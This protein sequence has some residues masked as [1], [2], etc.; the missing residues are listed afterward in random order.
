MMKCRDCKATFNESKIKQTTYENYYGVSS[1]FLH[2]NPLNLA[3]CPYCE[4]EDIE[5]TLICEICEEEYFK[6]ELHYAYKGEEELRVCNE[7]I[8]ECEVE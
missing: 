2:N 7:C 6:D 1:E 3:V 8:K 4:S 5:E